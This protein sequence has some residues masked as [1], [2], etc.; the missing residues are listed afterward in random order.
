MKKAKK[1]NIV[2]LHSIPVKALKAHLKSQCDQLASLFFSLCPFT[3]R[4]IC[5]ENRNPEVG[6]KFC[7]IKPTLN[8]RRLIILPSVENFAK[9]GHA[10]NE[11]APCQLGSRKTNTIAN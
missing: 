7:P 9:S 2:V 10:A 5:Q 1:R 4:K 11:L 8:S 6:S 3:G